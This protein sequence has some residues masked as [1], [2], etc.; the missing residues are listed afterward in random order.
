[1]SEEFAT[2]NFR[3]YNAEPLVKRAPRLDPEGLDL[4]SKF[5]LYEARK[6]MSAMDALKHSYFGSLGPEV[7]NLKDG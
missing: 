1:M 3:N 2:Y 6:R 4:V 5:L 7:H